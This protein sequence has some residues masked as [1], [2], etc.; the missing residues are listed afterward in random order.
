MASGEGGVLG[1]PVAVDQPALRQLVEQAR[2]LRQ[3]QHVAAGQQLAHRP[4]PFEVLIDHHPEEPGGEPQRGDAEARERLAH[5]VERQRTRRRDRQLAAVSSGP[6]ISSVEASKEAGRAA[7]R[8]LRRRG[9][10]NRLPAP[11]AR[12]PRAARPPLSDGRWSPRCRGRRRGSRRSAGRDR[13]RPP[14][15]RRAARRRRR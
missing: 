7:G 9:R 11:A 10:R 14:A 8:P 6:Q 15:R 1:R 12:S 5:L 2:D 4:Q 13:G 3:R